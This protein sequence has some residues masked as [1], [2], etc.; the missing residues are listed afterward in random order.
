GRDGGRLV[1]AKGEQLVA[2][3]LDGC[4]VAWHRLGLEVLP[5][6]AAGADFAGDKGAVGEHGGGG[7]GGDGDVVR[8]FV[9]DVIVAGDPGWGADGLAGDGGAV[10]QRLPADVAPVAAD[11]V[12][13]ADVADLDQE[14]GPDRPR[15][16]DAELAG[17][18]GVAGGPAVDQDAVDA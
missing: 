9:G 11:R 7:G 13:R 3:Y 5:G 16:A 2:S 15:G 17:A 12:R 18:V 4:Q 1:R 8:G 10:G 14:R 6:G